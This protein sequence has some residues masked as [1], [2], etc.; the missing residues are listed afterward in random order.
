[1]AKWPKSKGKQAAIALAIALLAAAWVFVE[2]EGGYFN[3]FY[4]P[5]HKAYPY[6]Y[7]DVHIAQIALYRNCGFTLV[8][9][10]VGLFVMQRVLAGHRKGKT[11]RALRDGPPYRR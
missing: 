6:P 8:G 1:V 5:P 11:D 10:F 7:A 3:R 4:F 2:I 9:V